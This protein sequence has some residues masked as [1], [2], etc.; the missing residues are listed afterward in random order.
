M[1]VSK[2]FALVLL[3]LPVMIHCSSSD[4]DA[5]WTGESSSPLP[6]CDIRLY[7]RLQKCM[8]DGTLNQEDCEK[9]LFNI[10]SQCSQ[11]GTWKQQYRNAF[12]HAIELNDSSVATELS[13]RM[14]QPTLW[15]QAKQNCGWQGAALGLGIVIG[16]FPSRK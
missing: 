16:W 11:T 3:C 10:M 12:N 13:R 14:H 15:Q 5:E 6:T 4:D 2:K 1:K 8:K 9:S 7:K